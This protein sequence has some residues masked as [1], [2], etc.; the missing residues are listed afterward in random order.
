MAT[1]LAIDDELLNKALKIGGK[2]TKKD[3]VNEALKEFIV[4]REQ[5]KVLDLFGTVE[6]FDDYQPKKARR[7]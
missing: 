4:R 7:L 1:N 5:Q 2:R 6:Y 3:T